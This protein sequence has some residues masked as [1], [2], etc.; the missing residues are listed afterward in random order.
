[1]QQLEL[2]CMGKTSTP[3][4]DPVF[5]QVSLEY[6]P[7]EGLYQVK[8]SFDYL[9]KYTCVDGFSADKMLRLYLQ[10]LMHEIELVKRDHRDQQI[11][12]WEAEKKAH[13]YHEN[14]KDNEEQR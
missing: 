2:F 1:M 9:S 12:K 4:N 13:G 7:H 6:L 3:A 10:Q 5:Y 11:K 14:N 8:G